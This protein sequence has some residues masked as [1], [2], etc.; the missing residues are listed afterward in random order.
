MLCAN[1]DVDPNRIS[2]MGSGEGAVRSAY[3]AA[4]EPR[5]SAVGVFGHCTTSRDAVVHKSAEH[6]WMTFA[7]SAR[8]APFASR[9]VQRTLLTQ[10][11]N[12]GSLYHCGRSI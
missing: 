11:V 5:V 12:P 8:P 2:T 1:A 10:Q 7:P 3:L 4:L 6:S 9:P